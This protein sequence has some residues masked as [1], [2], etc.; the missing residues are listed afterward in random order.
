MV[1]VSLQS[2][3]KQGERMFVRQVAARTSQ[4][5]C[6]G[7]ASLALFQLIAGSSLYGQQAGQT[8]DADTTTP[9]KHVIVIID[10]N[11]SFDHVFATYEPKGN[12]TIWNLLSEGIINADG[13]PGPNFSKAAQNA[14][15]DQAP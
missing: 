9:I 8:G 13:S 12:Q 10:E 7:V 2:A 5:L 4:R 3:T 14:A 1:C 11:R 15:T 6:M